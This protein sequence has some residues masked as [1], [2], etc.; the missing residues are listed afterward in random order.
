[1]SSEFDSNGQAQSTLPEAVAPAPAAGQANPAT[2]SFFDNGEKYG[3]YVKPTAE[4]MAAGPAAQAK[5]NL[6]AVI[7]DPSAT[8][9]SGQGDSCS[10]SFRGK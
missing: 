7:P 5:P 4:Q 6:P 8:D 10:Q 1:M 2:A 9:V 3:A